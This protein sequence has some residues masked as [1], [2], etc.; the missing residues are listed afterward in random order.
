M[1]FN[2]QKPVVFLNTLEHE[3]KVFVKLWHKPDRHISQKLKQTDGVKFSKTYKCYVMHKTEQQ[4]ALLQQQ[5]E[6]VAQVS[7]LYLNRPKRL[8]PLKQT[9]VTSKNQQF[10]QIPKYPDLV[11]LRLQPLLYKERTVLQISYDYNR[12]IYRK[13]CQCPRVKWLPEPK[14]FVTG[15]DSTSLHQLLDQLQGTAQIWLAQ[16]LK[17]K[18]LSVQKRLWEQTYVKDEL[19]ISCPLSY[20]EKLLLLNYSPSTI[21]TYHGLLLRFLNSFREKGLKTI[22]EF[23]AEQVN[24]YH[25]SLMQSEFYSYSFINQSINAIKFYYQ[26]VLQRPLLDLNQVERPEKEKKLP[27]VMSKEEVA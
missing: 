18:D 24:D 2:L 15:P 4:V 22:E 23:T 3:G 21:R 19:F 8:R 14:C 17:L 20:L 16:D 26:R 1:Y 5:L 11:T 13:L 9:A 25:R 10:T 6:G 27:K 12:D 7:T